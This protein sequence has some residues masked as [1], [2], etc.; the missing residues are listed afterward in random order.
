M[1]RRVAR[2]AFAS[3]K[4]PHCRNKRLSNVLVVISLVTRKRGRRGGVIRGSTRESRSRTRL[5]NTFPPSIVPPPRQTRSRGRRKENAPTVPR[6]AR[7]R[8]DSKRIKA[9]RRNRL[10][11]FRFALSAEDSVRGRFRRTYLFP[12]PPLSS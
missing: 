11:Q 1:L 5:H 6:R 8:G 9:Q 10:T 3:I 7:A 2:V 12:E 4:P